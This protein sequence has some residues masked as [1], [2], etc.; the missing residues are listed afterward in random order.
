VLSVW[1]GSECGVLEVFVIYA[2]TTVKKIHISTRSI[3]CIRAAA[4]ARQ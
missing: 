1:A 3:K 4:G 2:F